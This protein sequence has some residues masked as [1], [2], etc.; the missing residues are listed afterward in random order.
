MKLESILKVVDAAWRNSQN[1]MSDNVKSKNA[2]QSQFCVG[3]ASIAYISKVK[4][5]HC[6]MQSP[7]MRIRVSFVLNK[8]ARIATQKAASHVYLL[9]LFCL[10]FNIF[11]S[12]FNT[13]QNLLCFIK[14]NI[15][16]RRLGTIVGGTTEIL[17]SRNQ[18]TPSVSSAL[19]PNKVSKSKAKDQ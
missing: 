10:Y 8:Q 2:H 3:E 14:E 18:S 12:M 13:F 19:S 11:T 5:L 16:S 1:A 7:K 9:S 6:T 4:L 15:R 17:D